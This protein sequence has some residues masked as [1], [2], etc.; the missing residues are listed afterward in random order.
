MQHDHFTPSTE[1]TTL[2]HIT[3]HNDLW[4]A[5]LPTVGGAAKGADSDVHFAGGATGHDHAPP[6]T[7]VVDRRFLE[8]TLNLH[9]CHPDI[10]ILE[11]QTV[12]TLNGNHPK[13]V[14]WNINTLGGDGDIGRFNALTA[15]TA[16][17]ICLTETKKTR[18]EIATLTSILRRKGIYSSWSPAVRFDNGY[19]S[20]GVATWS[21]SPLRQWEPEHPLL[22]HWSN[23]GRLLGVWTTLPGIDIPTL[24]VNLYGFA[25]IQADV[26]AARAANREFLDSL[27]L[28]LA[29]YHHHPVMVVGDFN[30]DASDPWFYNLI[31]NYVD[32]QFHFAPTAAGA[33]PT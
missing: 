17:V 2:R 26:R 14:S 19:V 7:G 23:Q 10:P 22:Q 15:L 18:G 32:V 29:A 30:L 13:V 28:E 27:F 25:A 1:L 9:T 21:R 6:I 5:P 20:A 8:H 3:G 11:S 33:Y 31:G 24:I 4:V 12:D 16:D